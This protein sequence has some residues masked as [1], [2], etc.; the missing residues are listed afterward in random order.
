LK[1]IEIINKEFSKDEAL[2][3]LARIFL[4]ETD[5]SD[6]DINNDKTLSEA[7]KS[8]KLKNRKQFYYNFSE[9]YSFTDNKLG[10]INIDEVLEYEVE[11]NIIL[12]NT[13]KYNDYSINLIYL[14]NKS[15]L[16][17]NLNE[18]KT[19]SESVKIVG[20]IKVVIYANSENKIMFDSFYIDKNSKSEFDLNFKE[21]TLD[22]LKQELISN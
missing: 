16:N 20:K 7:E 9:I 8:Y 17:H 3:E 1:I 18:F 14:N 2:S 19:H 11:K 12:K 5:E 13:K 6:S 22:K 4:S 21:T 15:L 10:W